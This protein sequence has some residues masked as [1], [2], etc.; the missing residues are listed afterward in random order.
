MPA[1]MGKG[2]GGADGSA[3]QVPKAALP[4]AGVHTKSQPLTQKTESS[5]KPQNCGDMEIEAPVPKKPKLIDN[6]ESQVAFEAEAKSPPKPRI[7]SEEEAKIKS[8]FE[9]VQEIIPFVW[10]LVTAIV[11]PIGVSLYFSELR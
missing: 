11:R 1:K 6:R 7:P 10:L 5:N 9:V 4:L 3:S 8:T 2:V